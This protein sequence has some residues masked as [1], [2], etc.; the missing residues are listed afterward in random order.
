MANKRQVDDETRNWV[1]MALRAAE[2]PCEYSGDGSKITLEFD[3]LVR[4]WMEMSECHQNLHRI[5]ALLTETFPVIQIA[6]AMTP[7]C[8]EHHERYPLSDEMN[9]FLDELS[10]KRM[11]AHEEQVK[12]GLSQFFG[13]MRG[14][15]NKDDMN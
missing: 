7:M 11:A 2:M 5:R 6:E 12:A 4:L 14:P 9:V 8:N 1:R 10:Q 13:R 3:D 15:P